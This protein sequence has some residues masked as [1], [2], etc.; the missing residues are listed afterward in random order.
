MYLIGHNK[1][2]MNLADTSDAPVAVNMLNRFIGQAK[3]LLSPKA[4]GREFFRLGYLTEGFI[5][6]SANFIFFRTTSEVKVKGSERAWSTL[7]DT[8]QGRIMHKSDLF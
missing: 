6:G 1:L 7:G 3:N 5:T 2:E 8:V 4:R